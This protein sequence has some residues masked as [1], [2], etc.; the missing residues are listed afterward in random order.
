MTRKDAFVP[1]NLRII[2]RR[3]ITDQAPENT[4]AAFSACLDAEI[5]WFQTEV[6]CLADGSLVAMA[7]PT[8]DRTTNGSGAL[9]S[10]TFDQVRR[11]DAG[12]WFASRYRLERV[13]EL[14]SIIELLSRSPLAA[15]VELVADQPKGVAPAELALTASRVLSQ[16]KGLSRIVVTSH[17]GELLSALHR[18]LPELPLGLVVGAGRLQAAL[19]QVVTQAKDAGCQV[20]VA[21]ERGLTQRRM[22]VIH[23][24]GL[25]VTAWTVDSPDRAKELRDFGVSAMISSRP[26]ELARTV[27]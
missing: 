12:A 13:P 19:D 6:R 18:E 2:A 25:S 22:D 16:V 26:T 21:E 23:D 3:G 9:A 15:M 11:L 7:D 27:S 14:A 5:E 10:H 17:S 1:Q 8:L 24:A 20:I 4:I